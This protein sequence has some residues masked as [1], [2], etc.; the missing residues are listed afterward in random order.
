MSQIMNIE[1]VSIL[2][3]F[4]K[5][6]KCIKIA[7]KNIKGVLDMSEFKNLKTL[8]CNSNKI[9]HI[10]GLPDTLE[11]LACGWNP[12]LK[13]LDNLPTGLKRLSCSSRFENKIDKA[14]FENSVVFSWLSELK[15]SHEETPNEA[16]SNAF[17]SNSYG[18]NFG[19]TKRKL[20]YDE[21]SNKKR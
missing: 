1:T 15:M 18:V 20:S 4:D 14:H 16:N 13:N 10:I 12:Q 5:N 11:N 17:G 21:K 9:T 8:C 2:N 6:S 7:D 19:S 3:S